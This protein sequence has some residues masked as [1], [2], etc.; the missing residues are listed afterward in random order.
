MMR[1]LSHPPIAELR[2][3]IALQSRDPASPDFLRPDPGSPLATAGAGREL[4]S[5][6]GALAPAASPTN[7]K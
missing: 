3:E 4:P 2:P 7:T 5:Y 1:W 6:V